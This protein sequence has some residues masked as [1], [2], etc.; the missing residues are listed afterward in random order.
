MSVTKS[1]HEEY[2]KQVDKQ[3]K[4]LTGKVVPQ[5]SEAD[6]AVEEVYKQLVGFESQ[7]VELETELA[8]V[9]PATVNAGMAVINNRLTTIGELQIKVTQFL[10]SLRK[11][12][13]TLKHLLKVKA[14]KIKTGD[15]V[16]S[17]KDPSL[18]EQWGTLNCVDEEGVLVSLE[19]TIDNMKEAIE[20][21]TSFRG[22]LGRTTQDIKYQH[23]I[24]AKAEDAGLLG[25]GA[26]A[27][28]VDR[29]VERARMGK[30]RPTEVRDAFEDLDLPG[31]DELPVDIGSEDF[32][33]EEVTP[34]VDSEEVTGLPIN[35]ENESESESADDEE[36]D[37]EIL[38]QEI[39]E[40]EGELPKCEHETVEEGEGV[41]C[42]KCGQ[43]MPGPAA[44]DEVESEDWEGVV[45]PPGVNRYSVLRAIGVPVEVAQLELSPIFVV[46]KIEE[47]GA[48]GIRDL[49]KRMGYEKKDSPDNYDHACDFIRD[50]GVSRGVVV[51]EG[52]KYNVGPDAGK[53][54]EWMQEAADRLRV[55]EE[56]KK[57]VGSED[58]VMGGIIDSLTTARDFGLEEPPLEGGGEELLPGIEGDTKTE[59][60]KAVGAGEM[61]KGEDSQE[62]RPV[63]HR[64]LDAKADENIDVEALANGGSLPEDSE[65]EPK[66]AKERDQELIKETKKKAEKEKEKREER[67]VEEEAQKK[68]EEEEISQISIDDLFDIEE[69]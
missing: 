15:R 54:Q 30:Q 59:S 49:A 40:N 20:L 45:L 41:Q 55:I 19:A 65:L 60:N 12:R 3:I 43:W 61:R 57:T 21:L 35:Y 25:S 58:E 7:P 13:T 26:A 33:A 42:L 2:L 67:T 34:D 10:P 52:R 39:D 11:A 5:I 28:S 1:E 16:I 46:Q 44:E 31:E 56:E 27:Q 32:P 36:G 14:A 69:C 68:E 6:A 64:Q 38:Q 23:K 17:R 8:R 18:R 51:K 66:L 24:I 47:G 50:W 48:G 62:D 4:A 63:A 53:L 29:A 22:D 9:K 37:K